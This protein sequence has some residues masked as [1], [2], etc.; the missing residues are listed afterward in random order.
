MIFGRA[1]SSTLC[2]WPYE[3]PMV[4]TLSYWLSAHARQVVESCPPLK[5]TS[6]FLVAVGA[7]AVDVLMAFKMSVVPLQLQI[8]C[9]NQI[10]RF[11]LFIWNI[12]GCLDDNVGF[13]SRF[14][15]RYFCNE[16]QLPIGLAE[17]KDCV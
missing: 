12:S 7:V 14:F 13:R 17:S 15:Q 4:S 10:L 2:R 9:Q 11:F 6:A 5:R 3:K 16:P 1:S 8:I